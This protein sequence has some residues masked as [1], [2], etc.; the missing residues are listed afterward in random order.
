[1][2]LAARDRQQ[3]ITAQALNI[4]LI[5]PALDDPEHKRAQQRCYVVLDAIL[6]ARIAELL[7]QGIDD[8]AGMEEVGTQYKLGIRTHPLR[9]TLDAY[10]AVKR[11]LTKR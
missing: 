2:G 5:P 4:A 1:M 8:A 3:R 11:R 10:R 6:A 7:T 9:A